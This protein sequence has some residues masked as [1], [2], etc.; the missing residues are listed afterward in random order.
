M[1]CTHPYG[2]CISISLASLVFRSFAG[3]YLTVIPLV[4]LALVLL[5]WHQ[6]DCNVVMVKP[7]N[8]SKV[9]HRPPPPLR[10]PKVQKATPR[11]TN[12]PAL[13]SSLTFDNYGVVQS[14]DSYVFG[15]V[16]VGYFETQNVTNPYTSWAYYPFGPSAYYLFQDVDGVLVTPPSGMRSSV[17][18]GG[19]DSFLVLPHPSSLPHLFLTISILSSPPS[20]SCSLPFLT[21]PPP[22]FTLP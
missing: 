2:L 15:P 20:L 4:L 1:C 6:W 17:P 22:S 10:S 3:F 16:Y 8:V 13:L 11:P 18:L 5:C 9:V 21:P 12:L 19:E 7:A 14:T